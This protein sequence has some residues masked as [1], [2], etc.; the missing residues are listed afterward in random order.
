MVMNKQSSRG[1]LVM[2][3]EEYRAVRLAVLVWITP[4]Q[5]AC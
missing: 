2:G 1:N 3:P 4:S 5:N